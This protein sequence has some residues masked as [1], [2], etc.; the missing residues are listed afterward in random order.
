MKITLEENGLKASLELGD[1]V[2]VY[3]VVSSLK[4]L[5]MTMTYHPNSIDQAILELAE[6]IEEA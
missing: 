1:G 6:E 3:D 5:L 2:T 4:G